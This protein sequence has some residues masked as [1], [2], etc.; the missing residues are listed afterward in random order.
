M[1]CKI[2]LEAAD[3]FFSSSRYIFLILSLFLPNKR[4]T[5]SPF[6]GLLINKLSTISRIKTIKMNGQM[7]RNSCLLDEFIFI[8]S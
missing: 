5:I 4:L 6:F 2:L 7:V 1:S 8:T 3:L